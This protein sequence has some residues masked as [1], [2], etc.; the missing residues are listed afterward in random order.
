MPAIVFWDFN[1][2]VVVE[3]FGKGRVYLND[4]AS[5]PADGHATTSSTGRSP[6]SC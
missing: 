4:P 1:H 2:F 3:G 5:G 6:A